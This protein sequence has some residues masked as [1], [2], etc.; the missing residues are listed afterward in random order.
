MTQTFA[1]LNTYISRFPGKFIWVTE[2]S[3]NDRPEQLP[4]EAYGM[5]YVS[6]W[7]TLK[8]L[9]DIMGITYFIASASNPYFAPETWVTESGLS[10]GI[11]TIVGNR[12]IA[13]ALR[14]EDLLND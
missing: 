11:G 10:K 14:L 3:R 4:P 2:A 9:P 8:R 1:I 7:E 13:N 5:E 12:H 6:F